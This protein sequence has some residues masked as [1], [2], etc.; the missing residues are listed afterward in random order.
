LPQAAPP[1]P[2][3]ETQGTEPSFAPRRRLLLGALLAC[4]GA[5]LAARPH[6]PRFADAEGWARVFDDPE[7]DA[8]QKPGEVIAALR[9][10]PEGT[11]ADI[12]AG[13]GYFTVRLA[14][15]LPR[16]RVIAS[17]IEPDMV[18]HVEQR[19]R[20][21]G[22][23]N[24]AAVLAAAD[25]PRLP[26]GLDCVLLVNTYHHIGDR[27]A[28][29]RRL[30]ARLKPEGTVAIIDYRRDS[31]SGPPAAMR[32]APQ[33]IVAEMTRAGYALAA[34]HTFLPRQHFLVFRRAAGGS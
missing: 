15:A 28:Y 34:E 3:A 1:Q 24:V 31:P 5:P 16:G 18:R 11:V 14:Q 7:R 12:G 2:R 33:T 20:S 6:R 29:F 9:L 10:P 19:A 13:T 17:D 4:L 21:L 26:D 23:V 8:W 22:L 27:V 30:A 25:D 32:L